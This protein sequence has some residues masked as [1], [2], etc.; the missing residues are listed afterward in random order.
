VAPA[1]SPIDAADSVPEFLAEGDVRD[2]MFGACSSAYG[3][4]VACAVRALPYREIQ[5]CTLTS[6]ISRLCSCKWHRTE[7]SAKVRS[8]TRRDAG[9]GPTP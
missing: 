7:S 5:E 9:V 2:G 8:S 6:E 3:R 4:E 1:Q